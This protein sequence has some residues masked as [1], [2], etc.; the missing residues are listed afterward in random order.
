MLRESENG[1]ASRLGRKL[2][3]RLGGL[4]KVGWRFLDRGKGF[5]GGVRKGGGNGV[6]EMVGGREC[7]GPRGWEGG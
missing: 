3:L 2:G 7:E 4:G 1:R 6:G 5:D